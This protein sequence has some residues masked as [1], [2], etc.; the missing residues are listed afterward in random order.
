MGNPSDSESM[1]H[2]NVVTDKKDTLAAN[3]SFSQ[4]IHCRKNATDMS[5][6]PHGTNACTPL[7]EMTNIAHD[8]LQSVMKSKRLFE[9]TLKQRKKHPETNNQVP[10]HTLSILPHYNKVT[11]SQFA[12]KHSVTRVSCW[13]TCTEHGVNDV[14]MR[15]T[16]TNAT[17]LRFSKDDGGQPLFLLGQRD[18]PNGPHVG[19]ST[20]LS[21]W[22]SDEGCDSSLFT[23]KWIQNHYRWIVWKLAAMECRFPEQLG[24]RYLTYSHVLSQMKGRFEKELLNA[25]RPAVRKI[26]NRDCTASMPMILCVSQIL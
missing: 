3:P 6:S 23:G 10:T 13:A 18:A 12:A 2:A 17:K 14:T 26:L 5:S 11:L 16:S 1:E 15:V 25:R 20:D 4:N 8:S 19:K 9:N 22:L 21:K 7:H 24:G